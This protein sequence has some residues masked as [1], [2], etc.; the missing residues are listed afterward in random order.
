[1]LKRLLTAA[2]A[3]VLTLSLAA[4]GD[5]NSANLPKPNVSG[6]NTILGSDFQKDMG[7]STADH[8]QN[9]CKNEK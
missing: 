5:N 2:L 3:V 4:C 8:M 1:M 7:Q 9:V 6:D